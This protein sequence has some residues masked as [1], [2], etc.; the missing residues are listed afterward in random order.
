MALLAVIGLAVGQAYDP[1]PADAN[2]EVNNLIVT[3]LNVTDIKQRS[4]L[5]TWALTNTGGHTID[6]YAVEWRRH[7]PDQEAGDNWQSEPHPGDARSHV[8][9]GLQAGGYYDFRVR[10]IADSGHYSSFTKSEGHQTAYGP[11]QASNVRVWIQVENPG[12]FP[13]T[14]PTYSMT[15]AWDPPASRNNPDNPPNP[16]VPDLGGYYVAHEVNPGFV[17]P[18]PVVQKGLSRRHT[19][20]GLS[21]NTG[22]GFYVYACETA[23]DPNTCG[24]P[25]AVSGS[26]PPFGPPHEVVGPFDIT[27]ER[28]LHRNRYVPGG[29]V[30]HHF[31]YSLGG[32]Q[33]N[34]PTFGYAQWFEL[35]WS[36]NGNAPW[37][38][39]GSGGITQTGREIDGL[40]VT[41]FKDF[42]NAS[43]PAH[44]T[45]AYVRVRAANQTGPGPWS[46]PHEVPFTPY[47]ARAWADTTLTSATLHWTATDT[48][49]NAEIA[50][51]QVHKVEYSRG[52]DNY[53]WDHSALPW[54]QPW[55]D[56]DAGATSYEF[57]DLQSDKTYI[58]RVRACKSDGS[59][60]YAVRAYAT[61]DG[62][63]RPPGAVTNL[64]MGVN[65]CR[66]DFRWSLTPPDVTKTEG[67]AQ[68]Y[69]FEWRLDSPDDD[70]TVGVNWS[71]LKKSGEDPKF[72]GTS[73]SWQ[74][75]AARKTVV[76]YYGRDRNT[77]QE[78]ERSKGRFHMRV[79]AVNDHGAGP[80]INTG[81]S[82]RVHDCGIAAPLTPVTGES[83]TD[84]TSGTPPGGRTEM[85]QRASVTVTAAD[86]VEIDEGGAGTYT[87]VLDGQPIG[88]VVITASSDNDDVTTQPASLTFTSGN[89]DT[90]QT[91][92]VRAGDDDDSGDDTAVINHAVNGAAGYAGITVAS[93]SVSV[94]D[95]DE[96]GVTVTPTEL[97]VNEGGS[98]T[99]TVVLDTQPVGDVSILVVASTGIS[100]QPT[101]LT[102]TPDNWRNA[103]TITVTA[104]HDAD[105]EDG[106]GWIIHSNGAGPDSGY[107]SVPVGN[108]F[109][110]IIDDDEP[111]TL[112]A[113]QEEPDPGTVTVSAAS[114]SVREGGP[115]ATYTVTLDVEPTENVTIA[116]SSDNGDVTTQP[117]SLTFTTGN[118]Q[119][120]QTVSVSAGQ[121]GD[122]ADD[123]AT[124]SHTASGG[125][126]DGVAVASV[127]VSVTDDDSDRAVLEA[128]YDATGG[129]GWSNKGNWGSDKPLSQWHGVTANG[130][131][132]VTQLS[133]R[134]N[135]L[136]GSLPAALG[137]L[138]SL[139]VLSLDR[140]SIS[141]SLPSELGNL[142]NL[143]R[144]AMNR[145]NLTGSI[146][147]ELGSLSNLSIIG[148]ARNQLSGSL[149]TSLGNLSGLTKVSLHD[150]TGLSGAL[151]SGFTNLA[152][153][154][155]LAIANTG[156]CLPDTQAFDD[157][158]AG[159]PDKPGI[160]GLA[161]CE[162]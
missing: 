121:D 1:P 72:R 89:W 120:A 19:F 68:Y 142:S 75:P 134:N 15:L 158:L 161:D 94:R 36:R 43:L 28:Q 159:V 35:E 131:G 127:S 30:A 48:P 33:S 112:P 79:R 102:F 96:A 124:L 54:G 7:N 109:V 138:E 80:W 44:L 64:S 91:V 57:T 55:T 27:G 58:L 93:V 23:N 26:T 83:Y 150:N 2:H 90:P 154:Q 157:W 39:L 111:A 13:N 110:D 78:V 148:L 106:T 114:L 126:Y 133:L 113:Q 116:V 25:A 66:T 4:V 21:L 145:N 56:V 10:A 82:N 122:K 53:G 22:Y 49:G 140:N 105:I 100:A 38:R 20:G 76:K 118:W 132:Q 67:K 46:S 41:Q 73:G 86:P 69:E 151:P 18:G 16:A 71:N 45:S 47:I 136:S 97:S 160:D 5:L 42:A 17:V 104:D 147:T 146:P 125:N 115:A 149:P 65:T 92:T 103:R 24:H 98:A 81:E 74:V 155:R 107:D 141:G 143:T 59:C 63:S 144:L 95:D 119:S 88:D 34:H 128:F 130:S 137:K 52:R 153:L 101:E 84:T 51:F 50:K 60:S 70:E 152:N 99:Y 123:S 162:P 29:T 9:T 61:I 135:G 3:G 156:L 87:V 37:S 12:A 8:L 11:Y 129:S 31:D 77:P 40:P 32:A 62:P 6:R 108:V 14:A 117:S 139:Q 85:N